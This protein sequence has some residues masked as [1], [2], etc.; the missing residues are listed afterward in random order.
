MK[1]CLWSCVV[2]REAFSS[3]SV[4]PALVTEL[5]GAEEEVTDRF[6]VTLQVKQQREN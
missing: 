1:R 2:C 3:L 5:G 4:V 6:G